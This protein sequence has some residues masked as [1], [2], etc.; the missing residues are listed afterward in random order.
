LLKV[1]R[2]VEFVYEIA[3]DLQDMVDREASELRRAYQ[4]INEPTVQ[5]E[6]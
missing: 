6:V 5:A 1:E 4:L 2:F 3:P